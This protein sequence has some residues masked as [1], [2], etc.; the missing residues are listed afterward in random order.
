MEPP[1]DPGGAQASHSDDEQRLGDGDAHRD[2]PRDEQGREH[3]RA[4]VDDVV[5]R[6]GADL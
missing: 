1:C 5:R 2:E 6:H 3:H 4:R